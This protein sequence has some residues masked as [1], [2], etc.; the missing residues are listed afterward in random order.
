MNL[1]IPHSRC[2]LPFLRLC[3]SWSRTVFV[4]FSVLQL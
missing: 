1:P 3:P 2:Q 4:V